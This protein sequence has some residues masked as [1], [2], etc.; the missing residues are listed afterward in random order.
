M[1]MFYVCDKWKGWQKFLI[2]MKYVLNINFVPNEKQSQIRSRYESA[3]SQMHT[4]G[5]ISGQFDLAG[6]IG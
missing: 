6:N 1:D 5:R 4:N 2:L 3:A